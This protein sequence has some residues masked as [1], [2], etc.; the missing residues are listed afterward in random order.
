MSAT[1][2]PPRVSF[3][4]V[5][6]LSLVL[7]DFRTLLFFFLVFISCS[8]LLLFSTVLTTAEGRNIRIRARLW[9]QASFYVNIARYLAATCN[10][11]SFR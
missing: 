1:Y 5:R 11:Y 2:L 6:S 9:N 4:G 3:W 8:L 10:Q 7:A